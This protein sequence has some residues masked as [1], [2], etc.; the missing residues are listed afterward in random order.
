MLAMLRSASPL[1]A[2]I[3]DSGAP[4]SVGS[5]ANLV[6]CGASPSLFPPEK[7]LQWDDMFRARVKEILDADA[8][9]TISCTDNAKAVASDPLKA[10]AQDMP[11]WKDAPIDES[12]MAQILLDYLE[13]YG[14]AE[15]SRADTILNEVTGTAGIGYEQI[16][17]A[18]KK[19]MDDAQAQ[20]D[21]TREAMKRTLQ[22]LIGRS[23][24]QPL[25]RSFTCLNRSSKDIRNIFGLLAEESACVP[26]RTWDTKT[27]LRDLSQTTL[28]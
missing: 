19:R 3:S 14:C 26:V 16:G 28:W 6:A 15:R 10:L 27:S 13:T 5:G 4:P 20:L 25:D 2:D 17:T 7:S 9:V 11:K 1:G 12:D 24:L 22:L 8:T 21:A 23:K 18:T